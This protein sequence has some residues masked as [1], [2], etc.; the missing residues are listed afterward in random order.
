MATETKPTETKAKQPTKAEQD[1]VLSRLDESIGY[2]TELQAQGYRTPKDL[3]L[4]IR[5]TQAYGDF[6]DALCRLNWRTRGEM[7]IDNMLLIG[8]RQVTEAVSQ[9]IVTA[10]EWA[11]IRGGHVEGPEGLFRAL[12]EVLKLIRQRR[13]DFC[14]AELRAPKKAPAT[15]DT[16]TTE[17]FEAFCKANNLKMPN[18]AD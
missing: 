2:L 16:V 3:T 8:N 5:V 6:Y 15:A 9:N 10:D 14:T 4:G 18:A 12:T 11:A 13:P 1:A 17:F 7:F